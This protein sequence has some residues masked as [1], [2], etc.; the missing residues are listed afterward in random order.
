MEGK[1]WSAVHKVR[2]CLPF[3]MG[4]CW[5]KLYKQ[6]AVWSFF[7]AVKGFK[8]SACRRLGRPHLSGVLFVTRLN[9][10]KS[11][12]MHSPPYTPP[13]SQD[14]LH[15]FQCNRLFVRNTNENLL[16]F[17]YYTTLLQFLFFKCSSLGTAFLK[18]DKL[19]NTYLEQIEQDAIFDPIASPFNLFWHAIVPRWVCTSRLGFRSSVPREEHSKS[20]TEALQ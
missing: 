16:I 18:S 9:G 17:L 19:N 20:K 11:G 4:F 3:L 10:K 12:T 15:V 2:M 8:M 13:K 14:F 6:L 5:H 7:R 1:Y